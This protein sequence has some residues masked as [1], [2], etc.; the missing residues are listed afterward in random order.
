MTVTKE[1]PKTIKVKVR[2][3]RE[4]PQALVLGLQ[5]VSGKANTFRLTCL[6]TKPLQK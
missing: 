3:T 2:L 1:D 5:R 6:R 4:A